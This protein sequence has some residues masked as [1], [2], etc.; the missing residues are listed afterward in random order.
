MILGIGT[1]MTS[2]ARIDGALEKH[3]ARFVTRCFST[4]ESEKIEKSAEMTPQLRAASYAKRWAAKEACAKALG[5]GIR[6]DIYLKDIAVANN[7]DG[8]PQLALSGG[9]KDRLTA[10]T[11]GGMTARIDVSLT[12]EAGMA[13]AF[14]VISAEAA[15]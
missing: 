6:N 2:I 9:A 13:L 5:L 3:G 12:D 11:P 15:K 8:R 1:D 14:V 7:P 4:E 10:I